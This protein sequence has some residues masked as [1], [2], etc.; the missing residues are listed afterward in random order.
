MAHPIW[1]DYFVTYEGDRCDFTIEHDSNI[2]YEGSA[3]RRPNEQII[4]IK[5][6][7]I[8]ADY[9]RK[10]PIYSIFWLGTSNEPY[11]YAFKV[12]I[13]DD[14][15]T[16]VDDVVFTYNY[17]FD[18]MLLGQ[19]RLV[20]PISNIVSAHCVVPITYTH[21]SYVGVQDGEGNDIGNPVVGDTPAEGEQRTAWIYLRNYQGAR[22]ISFWESEIGDM[23]YFVEPACTAQYALYYRNALGGID[24]LCVEGKALMKDDYTRHTIGVGT[25]NEVEG[26]RQKVNYQNDIA[27]S[28]AL[29]TGWINDEGAA[30]MHHLLGSTDVVLL[31]TETNTIYSVNIKNNN[32]EYKTYANNG[33]HLVRYDIEVELAQTLNRR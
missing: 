21:R 6:N 14:S 20:A 5:I 26:A 28:W 3:V 24:V 18:R 4:S 16:E 2:I 11:E 12:T 15:T 13:Y 9:M 25:S 1:L 10:M 23:E 29:H 30:N 31:D 17:S 8:C 19:G 7:D 32:C 33:N 22:H 27:R